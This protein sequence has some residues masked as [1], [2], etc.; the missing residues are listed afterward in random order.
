MALA[1]KIRDALDLAEE[2]AHRIHW[3]D[4][5]GLMGVGGEYGTCN[6][7]EP[8]RQRRRCAADRKILDAHVPG[9]RQHW[10]GPGC[11]VC[12]SDR[13]GYEETW[14]PDAWPCPTLSAIA[15]AYNVADIPVDK[16]GPEIV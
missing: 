16:T 4:C 3:W 2:N 7:D 9:V 12:L 15:D 13:E 5:D 8:D 14:E 6:C 10:N 11:A 1:D